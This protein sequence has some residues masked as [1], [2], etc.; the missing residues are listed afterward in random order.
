MAS[1]SS[2]I[3]RDPYV[4]ETLRA[5]LRHQQLV[6]LIGARGT[7]KTIV[8]DA[9]SDRLASNDVVVVR[10]DAREAEDAIDLNG[11][12]AAALGCPNDELT[13]ERLEPGR[14]VRVIVDN[15]HE[16]YDRPW[17]P[18]LQENWRELL[19][20]EGASGRIGVVLL[21]RPLF[22]HVAGGHGSPLLGLGPVL[23]VRPLSPADIHKQFTVTKE[24]AQAIHRKTGG[25]PALTRYLLDA[26]EYDITNIGTAITAFVNEQQRYM[27]RLA[28]DHQLAAMGIL[29]DLIEAKKRLPEPPLIHAHYGT[30]YSEGQE[31]LND[32]AGSGLIARSN[33]GCELAAELLRETPAVRQFVRAP[34]PA[35]A[36]IPS[37]EQAQ[38]AQDIYAIENRLRALICESLG[39]IDRAWWRTRVPTTMLGEAES[40]RNAE[41]ESQAA[42]E[43]DLHPIMYLTLGELFEIVLSK[44]NWSGVFAIEMKRS[45]EMMRGVSRDLVAVR[46]KVAHSRPVSETDLELARNAARRIGLLD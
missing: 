27:L 11:P 5:A 3:V 9:L 2:S 20:S 29:A 23:V 22:R 28:E 10:L 19:S 41:I 14:V 31:A 35:I 24:L 36:T 17:F 34:K 16:F 32:L 30:A 15:C 12:L 6:A 26:V 7:G 18:Y 38:C 4:I 33:G 42:S 44:E 25:H 45:A 21:G 13:S 8:A 43:Q 1:C 46:N 40:R 37:R 39:A